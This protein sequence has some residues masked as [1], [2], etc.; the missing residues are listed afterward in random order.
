MLTATDGVVVNGEERWLRTDVAAAV[1]VSCSE[2]VG[3]D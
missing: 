3:S 2:D 1:V